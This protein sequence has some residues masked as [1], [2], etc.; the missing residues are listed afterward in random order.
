MSSFKNVSL[1][2]PAL[3]MALFLG[4]CHRDMSGVKKKENNLKPQTTSVKPVNTD[5]INYAGAV[6]YEF[7]QTSYSEP[8]A[9]PDANDKMTPLWKLYICLHRLEKNSVGIIEVDWEKLYGLAT[10]AT[11]FKREPNEDV[12]TPTFKKSTIKYQ[13]SA[14]IEQN[15]YA[16]MGKVTISVNSKDSGTQDNPKQSIKDQAFDNGWSN[17]FGFRATTGT[18]MSSHWRNFKVNE[19]GKNYYFSSY[20]ERFYKNKSTGENHVITECEKRGQPYFF[21]KKGEI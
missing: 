17:V 3:L 16:D 8:K 11:Y 10:V 6:I 21:W 20:I 14:A 19:D 9:W 15:E 18:L 13:F 2:S 4:A 1:L 12:F 5:D 7:G